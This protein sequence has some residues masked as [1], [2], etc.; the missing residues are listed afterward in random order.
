MLSR[1]VFSLAACCLATIAVAEPD[2]E[3]KINALKR[4]YQINGN[5][6]SHWGSI[7]VDNEP[8]PIRVIP[9]VPTP[10]I[11][12]PPPLKIEVKAEVPPEVNT[13]TRHHMHKVFTHNGKSWRCRK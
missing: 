5:V 11:D 7:D 12:I 4:A 13:C 1:L 6:G 9:I 3:T 8:T 2:E 10:K